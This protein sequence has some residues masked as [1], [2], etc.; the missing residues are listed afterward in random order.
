[1]NLGFLY[2][3]LGNCDRAVFYLEQ[4]ADYAGIT[5]LQRSRAKEC[6]QKCR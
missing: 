1:M 3:R 4:I 5:E 2:F 6:I